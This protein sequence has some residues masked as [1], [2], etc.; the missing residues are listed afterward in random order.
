MHGPIEN[1]EWKLLILENSL[2]STCETQ[3]DHTYD[4]DAPFTLCLGRML[5]LSIGIR[6]KRCPNIYT[7]AEP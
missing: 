2:A 4:N 3:G 1:K 7:K 5:Q 6:R